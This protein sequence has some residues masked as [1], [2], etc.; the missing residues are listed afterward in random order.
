M[1]IDYCD[2]LTLFPIAESSPKCRF[3]GPA[4]VT[5]VLEERGMDTTRVQLAAEATWVTLGTSLKAV[6]VPAE[7]PTVVRDENGN[8]QCIGYIIEYRGRRI[9]HS[10]DTSVTDEVLQCVK[11]LGP[12]EIAFLP[13]NERHYFRD[14]RGIIGNMTIR[15]AFG[16][17]E[18]IGANTLVPMHWDM[19]EPNCVPREEIELAYKLLKPAFK[20]Q[21][22]PSRL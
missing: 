20:M 4:T 7:H 12:I 2:P 9:Y 3:I 8:P 13:V 14:R 18:E 16:F 10:G 19:F 17:A 15:E 11:D 1:H 22:Y 21:F 6:A 5:E